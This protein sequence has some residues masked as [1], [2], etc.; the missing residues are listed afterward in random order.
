MFLSASDQN[1]GRRCQGKKNR[2]RN[3]KEAVKQQGGNGDVRLGEPRGW[4]FSSQPSLSWIKKKSGQEASKDSRG[5]PSTEGVSSGTGK[6]ATLPE[7]FLLSESK[8]KKKGE[9]HLP[10][11]EGSALRP[12][13]KGG[14]GISL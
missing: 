10:L 6:N 12:R 8:K 9:K 4:V 13:E 11:R 5:G 14:G 2:K 3:G 1:G 7:A